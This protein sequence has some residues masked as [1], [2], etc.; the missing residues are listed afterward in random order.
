MFVAV[1]SLFLSDCLQSC[2]HST[3]SILMLRVPGMRKVLS[4]HHMDLSDLSAFK[5]ERFLIFA[6]P[7]GTFVILVLLIC[8][9]ASSVI[10]LKT[11]NGRGTC[12]LPWHSH[13]SREQACSQLERKAGTQLWLC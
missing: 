7:Q 9:T 13:H 10:S 3:F 6:F 1:G 12:R 4:D 8:Y 11:V 2:L 5:D